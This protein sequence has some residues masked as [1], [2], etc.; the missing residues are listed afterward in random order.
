MPKTIQIAAVQM[1]ARPAPTPE[2]L[3]RAENLVA[4]AAHS[5]AQLVVLPEVFNTGYEY[6]DQNFARAE[7][8][9]GQTASWMLKTALS[10]VFTWPAAFCARTDMISITACCWLHRMAASGATTRTIPGSGNGS[11]SAR[12][13]ASASR[14]LNWARS[15]S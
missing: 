14:I 11:I 6:S 13:A 2:R 1:D 12:A 15:V 10:T 3:A 9:D 7:A 8:P 5:G 4:Q